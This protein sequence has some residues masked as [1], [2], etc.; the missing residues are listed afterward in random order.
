MS[1]PTNIDLVV[2]Q[3]QASIKMIDQICEKAKQDPSQAQFYETSL[4]KEMDTLR[5]C[6]ENFKTWKN[7]T[8]LTNQEKSI[9]TKT[10][11]AIEKKINELKNGTKRNN[12]KGSD[13]NININRSDNNININ[14]TNNINNNQIENNVQ[15]MQPSID[16]EQQ[17]Q[18]T[19]LAKQLLSSGYIHLRDHMML[20]QQ[21]METLNRNDQ[22]DK[23]RLEVL[24]ERLQLYAKYIQDLETIIQNINYF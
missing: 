15:N 10:K 17:Q 1:Q 23:L 24:R 18:V 19:D 2:S 3:A 11:R 13:N 5:S 16:I 7:L 14:N 4:K 21:E 9:I 8:S 6:H 12:N 22:Q 20:V